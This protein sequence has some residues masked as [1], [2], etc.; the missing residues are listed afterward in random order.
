MIASWSAS[1]F[2]CTTLGVDGEAVPRCGRNDREVA[3][4]HEREVERA[5][6]RRGRQR[7]RVDLRPQLPQL[8]LG[9]HAEPVLFIYNRAA[10][11]P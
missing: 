2:H 11:D 4:A 8:L 3:C 7:Q 1:S 10:R 5:G 6:N 9:C